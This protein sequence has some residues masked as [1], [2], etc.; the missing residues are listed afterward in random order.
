MTAKIAVIMGSESD[1]PTMKNACTLLDQFGVEYEKHV[2]SAHRMP[3]EMFDFAKNAEERGIRV[4]IAGAGMAAHLP[5]MTAANTVLPVIGV[6][7]QTKALGGMDS[8]LSIVQMPT[9]IPVATTAIGNSGASNAA[10]LAL[11]I[12]GTS[13]EKLRVALK[14]YRQKLH[15]L[16]K[17]SS[18]ELE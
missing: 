6:P 9:G 7:G 17:E 4:I 11:E 13:D 5:G 2:I 8:L 3:D 16:A 18:S 12:L 14:V 10:L 15:D 1:W